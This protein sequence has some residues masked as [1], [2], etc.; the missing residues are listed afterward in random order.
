MRFTAVV[1]AHGKTATGIEV[2]DTV[3]AGLDGGT[4]PLITVTINEHTYASAIGAMGGKSLIPLSADNRAKAGVA[5]GDTIEVDIALDLAPRE[6][7]VPADLAASQVRGRL[8]ETARRA[9]RLEAVLAD[10]EQRQADPY[11]RMILE[12]GVRLQRMREQWL[13]ELLARATEPNVG[14]RPVRAA[15]APGRQGRANVR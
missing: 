7:E 4:R 12:Y 10:L 2:P 6:I 3:M 13:R 14:N 1:Q 15:G 9:E 11:R 8:E 5:A